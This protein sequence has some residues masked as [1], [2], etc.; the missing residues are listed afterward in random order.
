MGNPGLLVASDSKLHCCIL[1]DCWWVEVWG[2]KEK[3]SVCRHG[4]AL[5][6]VNGKVT[7]QKLK[8]QE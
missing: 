7:I 2:L 8:H 6:S 1:R 4:V 5:D 3:G